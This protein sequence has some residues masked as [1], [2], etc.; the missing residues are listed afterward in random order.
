MRLDGYLTYI[1][2]SR[3]Y[4]IWVIRLNIMELNHKLFFIFA[5]VLFLPSLLFAASSSHRAHRDAVE[6]EYVPIVPVLEHFAFDFEF[7][8]STG[9]LTVQNKQ[10][11]ISFLTGTEEVFI[12][13][14]VEFLSKSVYMEDGEVFIP[15]DGIDKMIH[16][17][18]RQ[19]IPWEYKGGIFIVGRIGEPE[20]R[21][22]PDSRREKVQPRRRYEYDIQTIVI[23]PGHGGKDPG[24]VGFNGIEEKDIVLN[25]AA[26]LK[27][28]LLKKNR[29][30]KVLITREKDEFVSLEERGKI[31][32][33]DTVIAFMG[34]TILKV[35]KS[36]NVFI[37]NERKTRRNP[38][39]QWHFE[40]LVSRVKEGLGKIT[41]KMK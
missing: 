1:L 12:N 23:D 4:F 34:G 37:E 8:P 38:K 41:K 26:E 10:G 31:A 15:S 28:E 21:S 27:R 25:V 16:V 35:W 11:N 18:L 19:N 22:V 9:I 14:K 6:T 3:K 29:D 32:N 40:Y 5:L 36:V 17:L 39:Y 7:Q 24:G 33:E 2:Y 30:N 20:R 13:G